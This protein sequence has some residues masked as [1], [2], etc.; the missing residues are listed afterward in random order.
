MIRVH[1]QLV[2][3]LLSAVFVE[4]GNVQSI[5]GHGRCRQQQCNP[6]FPQESRCPNGCLCHPRATNEAFGVCLNPRQMLPYGFM[7]PPIGNPI[8]PRTPS[9]RTVRRF[10]QRQ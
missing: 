9:P 1:L 5:E 8:Y 2:A 7:R 3:I 6:W 4:A 10:Q